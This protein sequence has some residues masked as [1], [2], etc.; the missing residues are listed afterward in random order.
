MNDDGNL[1]IIDCILVWNLIYIL[2]LI[3]PIS[4]AIT[5]WFV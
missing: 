5:Y 2:L 1:A 3:L 4:I